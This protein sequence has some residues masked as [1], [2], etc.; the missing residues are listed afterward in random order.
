MHPNVYLRTFWRSNFRPE[1]FVAMQFGE[2]YDSRF[3]NI[4]EPAIEAVPYGKEKLKAKRVDVSKSGD[5]ILTDIIDGIA[6]SLMVLADISTI[7]Q[8]SKTGKHY[9]NGNVMYE[10]G[11]A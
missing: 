6:H 8:D 10:V 7:G 1:I 9:R 5:S 2:P 4:I 11:L 3:K